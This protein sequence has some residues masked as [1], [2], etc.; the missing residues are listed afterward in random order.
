MRTPIVIRQVAD[1]LRRDADRATRIIA[2]VLHELR[3]RLSEADAAHVARHLPIALRPLWEN[4][5]RHPG[6][7]E[8]PYQL[9]L[10]GAVME[11]GG[12]PTSAEA[13]D[14]VVAVFV[15]MRR[16]LDRVTRNTRALLEIF[17][18]LPQD[19]AV[20]WH[21]AEVFGADVPRRRSRSVTARSRSHAAARSS[22]A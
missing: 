8:Q 22:A 19:L 14:A 7:V 21:A 17:G 5:D 9:E 6:M 2:A 12:F 13:E 20:L 18:Q 10:L 15:V 1:R 16:R 11:C 4:S 3:D